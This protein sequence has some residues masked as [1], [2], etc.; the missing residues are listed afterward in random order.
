MPK[1]EPDFI[2][3]LHPISDRQW[4]TASTQRLRLAL[5]VLL[6]GFGLRAVEV[7]PIVQPTESQD[8]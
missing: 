7:K 1:T 3:R 8:E 6:R 4:H 5:K 2:V